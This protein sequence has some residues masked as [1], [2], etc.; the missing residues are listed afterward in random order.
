MRRAISII[1]SK[2]P[3]SGSVT[4]VSLH[5]PGTLSIRTGKSYV[6]GFVLLPFR[7]SS[8]SKPLDTF[9]FSQARI[10][11]S[12]ELKKPPPYYW[13]MLSNYSTL[14]SC[15]RFTKFHLLNI[16]WFWNDFIIW[17]INPESLGGLFS[18]KAQS[19]SSVF[20]FLIFSIA[21]PILISKWGCNP[22]IFF[23]FILKPDMGHLSDRAVIVVN[24]GGMLFTSQ[25]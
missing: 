5:A 21:I 18:K 13:S 3:G 8:W 10:P 16:Y 1:L 9:P 24:S 22:H 15:Y 17:N 7:L 6:S 12:G 19:S 2:T 4:T 25:E 14:P 11:N 23:P 20:E